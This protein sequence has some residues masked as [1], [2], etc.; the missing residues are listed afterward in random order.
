MKESARNFISGFIGATIGTLL[1]FI[2]L[3]LSVS[4]EDRYGNLADW[5]GSVG[6]I[7][8]IIATV[9]IADKTA[10]DNSA[11]AK[12]DRSE[13]LY[14]DDLRRIVGF[15]TRINYDRNIDNLYKIA[16]FEFNPQERKE[17]RSYFVKG[18][19]EFLE[20][21]VVPEIQTTIYGMASEKRVNFQED[22]NIIM[23]E[24]IK[25]MEMN[26]HSSTFD[27]RQFIESLNKTVQGYKNMGKT[28]EEEINDNS[29]FD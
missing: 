18:T 20:M 22:L 8:A 21:K 24:L 10:K 1:G 23:S 5:V 12:K 29:N 6:T 2:I 25:V 7:L 9:L 11:Q 16:N 19:G 28:I 26:V 15:L 17:I 13:N 4:N 27:D 14:V 3:L